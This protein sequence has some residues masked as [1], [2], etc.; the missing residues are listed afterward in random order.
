MTTT[1][2]IISLVSASAVGF[3]ISAT[4]PPQQ[5]VLGVPWK[6]V[7]G[8]G[9]ALLMLVALVV[10]LRFLTQDRAAR[11]AE[12]SKDREHVEK[13]VDTC[14]AMTSKLGADFSA[15]QTNLLSAFREDQQAAR[16]ELQD[17][18]KEIRRS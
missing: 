6:D 9:A 12:R 5:E 7:A 16:R 13:V 8:G 18:V 10:F 17:L 11:D 4:V 3:T 2:T 1:A 14:T 15:T